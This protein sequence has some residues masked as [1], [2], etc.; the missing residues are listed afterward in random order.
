MNLEIKKKSKKVYKTI[1]VSPEYK[2]LL[3]EYCKEND[4]REKDVVE[5]LI[6]ELLKEK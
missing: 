4:Y 6:K 5:A 2:D 1:S 3:K